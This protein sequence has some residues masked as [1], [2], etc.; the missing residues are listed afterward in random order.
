MEKGG[1]GWAESKSLNKTF[2]KMNK[3]D[4]RTPLMPLKKGKSMYASYGP[5]VAWIGGTIL[6]QL[7][8]LPHCRYYGYIMRS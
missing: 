4:I 5:Q 7:L 6:I 8:S 3:F 1:G 2:L